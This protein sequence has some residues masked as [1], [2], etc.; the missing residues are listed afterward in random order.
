MPWEERKVS[1]VR[2]EFVKRVLAQ[3]ASKSALCRE[4]GISRPT[5]DKWIA[6][7]Q[8]G[9]AL[10]D[11]RRTPIQSPGRTIAEVE[12]LIIQYRR[13]HPAIGATKIRRILENEG[14]QGLPCVSTINRIL[15]RNHLIT[16]EAKLAAEPI[17]RFE[18][19][20][21]NEMWQADYKGHFAMG[22]GRRCH[23]LNII[24]DC[25]RFNL[26]C[27]AQFSET[28]EEIQPVMIRLFQEYGLPFS[29]LCDNGN[30][31]GTSQST[32]FSRFEV[33]LMELG[34]LTIHGRI[35]HPQTQGKEE[36]F[37]RSMTRELLAYTKI[38]DLADAQR[39]FD[40]YRDFYNKERP[41]H[42][43]NLDTPIQRYVPS[44]RAYPEK[45]SEWEYPEDCEIR[46]V[47][48]NGFF[49][50]GGQGYFLSEAFAGKNIAVRPSHIQGCISLFF[51]NFRIGRIDVEKR[52][53]TF[54]RI[55]L[56]E[57]DPRL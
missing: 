47:R 40:S 19:A 52:A 9:E 53:F 4:Y 12:E 50:Y 48:G 24:D 7:Y 17:Q 31:W 34:I 18:K 32:G 51:R 27:E 15:D 45:I 46:R 56:I 44:E 38:S 2:E 1:Q 43:L 28:F 49:N 37:N 35:R 23:P 26:C 13:K 30:P 42:A 36:S 20:K 8:A 22:D 55:Y 16:R 33:W 5:G 39:Q 29:F 54:R 3:E 10:E 14:H 6:R 41:H 11:R 57:G 25:S 21:P